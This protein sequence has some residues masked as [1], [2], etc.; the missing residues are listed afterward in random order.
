MMSEKLG[1]SSEPRSG[2][3]SPGDSHYY[4]TEDYYVNEPLMGEDEI[5]NVDQALKFYLDPYCNDFR[6]TLRRV[7]GSS[8]TEGDFAQEISQNLRL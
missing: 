1:P 3:L 7:M 5:E 2:D 8:A 4:N 6:P